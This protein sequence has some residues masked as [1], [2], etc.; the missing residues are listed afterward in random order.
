MANLATAESLLMRV[1]ES[2]EKQSAE[3][4]NLLGILYE[5]QAKWRLAR[6]CYGKAIAA[7]KNFV[8]AQSNMRRLYELQNFGKSAEPVLLGDE[9]AYLMM[10]FPPPAQNQSASGRASHG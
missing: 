5:A 8:P 4:F 9:A 10:L 3:Y 2:R 7:D 1:A 6:K